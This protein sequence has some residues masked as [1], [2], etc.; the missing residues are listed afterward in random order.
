VQE[1]HLLYQVFVY[2]LQIASRRTTYL[3][4][5]SIQRWPK[6]ETG[7]DKDCPKVYFLRN[8][9]Q[10]ET[11]IEDPSGENLHDMKENNIS[12]TIQIQWWKVEL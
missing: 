10:T 12:N 11:D 6:E 2:D 8:I 3:N 1:A 5:S 9:S 4:Y 7:G